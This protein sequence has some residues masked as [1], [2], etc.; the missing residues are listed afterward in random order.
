[1]NPE[2]FFKLSDTIIRVKAYLGETLGVVSGGEFP[3]TSPGQ[4]EDLYNELEKLLLQ[5]L[6]LEPESQNDVAWAFF[7]F[8]NDNGDIEIKRR[9]FRLLVLNSGK[10]DLF[11]NFIIIRKIINLCLEMGD[12]A[13]ARTVL[14]A[15]ADFKWIEDPIKR[16]IHI[17]LTGDVLGRY[18]HH[19][20][21]RDLV[22]RGLGLVFL[23]N[24]EKSP[25]SSSFVQDFLSAAFNHIGDEAFGKYFVPR[26][27]EAI[28]IMEPF[29]KSWALG[30]L[31]GALQMARKAEWYG[32]TMDS[33]KSQIERLDGTDRFVALINMTLSLKESPEGEEKQSVVKWMTGLAK[34]LDQ[35]Q[36]EKILSRLGAS[37]TVN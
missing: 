29:N 22:E 4:E 2:D 10:L 15:A 17:K 12:E 20:W 21:A 1:M 31:A 7:Q 24:D 26:V 13:A 8:V 5:G 14:E 18:A 16:L 32:T 9:F 19:P 34:R 36:R 30:H 27:L 35:E 23:Q 37:G 6:E 25:E 11:Q 3:G 28:R 33:V